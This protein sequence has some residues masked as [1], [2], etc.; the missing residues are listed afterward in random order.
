MDR[1]ME[2]F[3]SAITG[4][5]DIFIIQ[6][7]DE[8]E[9]NIEKSHEILIHGNPE[10]LRSVA[11][12]LIKLADTNRNDHADLLISASEHLYLRPGHSLFAQPSEACNLR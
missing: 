5:L 3:A 10:G 1:Y 6:N 9:G 8:F 11:A 2:K 7:E 4:N 12:L